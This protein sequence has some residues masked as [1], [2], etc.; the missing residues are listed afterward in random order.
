MA[1][2]RWPSCARFYG[3]KIHIP[4]RTNPKRHPAGVLQGHVT[5]S[6]LVPLL[7]HLTNWW[8]CEQAMWWRL[9]LRVRNACVGFTFL[10]WNFEAGWVLY[11]IFLSSMMLFKPFERS[12]YRNLT[13][14]CTTPAWAVLLIQRPMSY[15]PSYNLYSNQGKFGYWN[16]CFG[17]IQ[18]HSHE[19]WSKIVN[20]N[21]DPNSVSET[22]ITLAI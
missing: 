1:F 3:E 19:L 4:L 17:A 12:I 14:L 9:C 2:E 11:T 5:A 20:S 21:L 8:V 16:C 18:T 22:D 13:K 10:W 15:V 7:R 6:K